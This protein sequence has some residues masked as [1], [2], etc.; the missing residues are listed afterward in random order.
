MVCSRAGWEG[1][2]ERSAPR[3]LGLRAGRLGV[4]QTRGPKCC[5]TRETTRCP[6]AGRPWGARTDPGAASQRWVRGRSAASV[7]S[8]QTSL[9]LQRCPQTGRSDPVPIRAQS[10]GAGRPPPPVGLART[11]RV[12]LGRAPPLAE[13]PRV[14]C[15]GHGAPSA[16]CGRASLLPALV[17]RGLRPCPRHPQHGGGCPRGHTS[18]KPGPSGPA[19]DFWGAL[20][21]LAVGEA[22]VV[23]R[24]PLLQGG[25]RGLP[26]RA[27]RNGV[28]RGW[29]CP[30]WGSSPAPSGPA[31]HG[32]GVS[33]PLYSWGLD[34]G[35][36]VSPWGQGSEGS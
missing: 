11:C 4:P 30:N 1:R 32:G 19:R 18:P 7:G 2:A 10:S 31:G 16:H 29:A 36:G 5:L 17:S 22:S 33:A 14:P 24:C 34:A 25:C 21:S 26:T 6:R 13:R 28:G 3:L 15:P 35:P 8:G 9:L 12:G 20:A 23:G 27:K